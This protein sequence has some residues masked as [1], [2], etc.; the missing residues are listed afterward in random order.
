LG[1]PEVAEAVKL[2][3]E[4]HIVVLPLTDILPVRRV[5]ETIK[6]SLKYRR[7]VAS[8][9]E[10]GIVEPLV[11]APRQDSTGPH[12][13]VDGHL[14]HS[15]LLSL[16][17]TS[18][19]CLIANDDEGFTCSKRVNRLATV[20]EHRMIL[21]ALERGVS[22]EKLARA[23]NIDT[24][25]VRI[26]RTLLDGICPEVVDAVKDRAIDAQVFTLLRK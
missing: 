16:G 18:A 22:E 12:M 26:K 13:L 24:K 15:A 1:K 6:Q 9:A 19:P 25:Q 8:I 20:Q 17:T 11:V 3:F 5:P 7:I 2:A 14:R 21:S 23:L 10:V 4:R